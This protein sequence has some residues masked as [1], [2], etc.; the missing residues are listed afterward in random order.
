MKTRKDPKS[1]LGSIVQSVKGVLRDLKNW[2]ERNYGQGQLSFVR[3]H[4]PE[5]DNSNISNKRKTK[6][7]LS[8]NGEMTITWKMM[9]GVDKENHKFEA[10]TAQFH[11]FL[12]QCQI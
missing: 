7:K 6:A 11:F 10:G 4:V 12:D 8:E 9:G 1:Q 2:V 3:L 5:I